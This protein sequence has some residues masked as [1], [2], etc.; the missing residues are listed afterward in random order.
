MVLLSAI[1]AKVWLNSDVLITNER[2][3]IEVDVVAKTC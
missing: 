1:I 3:V 2:L